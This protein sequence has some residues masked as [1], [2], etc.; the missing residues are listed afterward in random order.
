MQNSSFQITLKGFF[1]DVITQL[2]RNLT[3]FWVAHPDF[4]R[5]GLALVEAWRRREQGNKEPLSRLVEGLIDPEFRPDVMKFID[6]P[7][8]G[9]IDTNAPGYVRSLIVADIKESDY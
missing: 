4:V 1:K 2:K 5:L 6:A 7:D 9:G 3:G 8:S